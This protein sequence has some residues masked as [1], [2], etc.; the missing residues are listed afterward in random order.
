V[1]PQNET[2]GCDAHDDATWDDRTN[3]A[4]WDDRTNDVTWDGTIVA[5]GVEVLG[6]KKLTTSHFRLDVRSFLFLHKAALI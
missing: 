6:V 4:T 2:E 3:D 5:W 1:V